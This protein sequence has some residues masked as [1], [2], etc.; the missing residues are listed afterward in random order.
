MAQTFIIKK[1][2][3]CG[4]GLD[5]NLPS[6]WTHVH[7]GRFVKHKKS[8]SL[9]DGM[10]LSKKL[11]DFIYHQIFFSKNLA[12]EII[13][14][15]KDNDFDRHSHHNQ[16]NKALGSIEISN[17]ETINEVNSYERALIVEKTTKEIDKIVENY[18]KF[19]KTEFTY[20]TIISFLTSSDEC[21]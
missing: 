20:R 11:K 2:H 6:Y 13:F 12:D 21:G 5:T 8:I 17:S 3:T 4:G 15:Y 14:E 9:Q 16:E 10:I 1:L 19:I 7:R 18:L